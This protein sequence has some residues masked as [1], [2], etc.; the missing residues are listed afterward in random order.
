M[1]LV[2]ASFCCYWWLHGCD[3]CPYP[4]C[5][6]PDDSDFLLRDYDPSSDALDLF[7]LSDNLMEDDDSYFKS[8]RS[9]FLYILRYYCLFSS[10]YVPST[11]DDLLFYYC[12]YCSCFDRFAPS[13]FR[14]RR[15][16]KGRYFTKMFRRLLASRLI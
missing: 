1:C 9:S 15:R 14:Y 13:F 8:L 3:T 11:L 6:I 12:K 2:L 16:S 7:S 4:D 10:K 5:M